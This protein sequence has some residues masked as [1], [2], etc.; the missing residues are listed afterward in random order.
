MHIHTELG[1]FMSTIYF[2]PSFINLLATL[3]TGVCTNK[4]TL[5]THKVCLKSPYT[6]LWGLLQAAVVIKVESLKSLSPLERERIR[7]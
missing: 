1:V 6:V 7:S 3:I 2:I 5:Q 4:F